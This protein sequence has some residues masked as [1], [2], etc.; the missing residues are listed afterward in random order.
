MEHSEQELAVLLDIAQTPEP[1]HKDMVS[2]ELEEFHQEQDRH[3]PKVAIHQAA[4]PYSCIAS[5]KQYA[6]KYI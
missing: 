5:F 3:Y 6:F 1:V 4:G 2:S